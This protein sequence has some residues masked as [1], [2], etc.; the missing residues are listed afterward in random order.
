MMA[1]TTQSISIWTLIAAL[2]GGSGVYAVDALLDMGDH[3]WVTIA[4]QNVQIRFDIEDEIVRINRW[5]VN[6]TATPDDLIRKAVLEDRLRRLEL[7]Q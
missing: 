6:G 5:I 3:R 4:S 7:E 2:S 1:F